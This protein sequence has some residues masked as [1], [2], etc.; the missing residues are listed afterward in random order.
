MVIIQDKSQHRVISNQLIKKIKELNTKEHKRM[1][2]TPATLVEGWVYD[3]VVKWSSS[4]ENI[5]TNPQFDI[6]LEI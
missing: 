1:E 6:S 5:K 3:L 2:L 4:L